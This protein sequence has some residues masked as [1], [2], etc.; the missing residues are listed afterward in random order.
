MSGTRSHSLKAPATDQPLEGLLIVA[1]G[2]CNGNKDHVLSDR[3][4]E[5]ARRSGRFCDVQV[6]YVRTEPK[7]EA[8]A[9]HMKAQRLV[10]LPLF[11][12]KGYYVKHTIPGRLA[13]GHD[14]RDMAGR[15][16]TVVQ[17]LGVSTGLAPIISDLAGQ[18]AQGAGFNVSESTLLLVAHGSTKDRASRDATVSV[19][20]RLEDTGRFGTVEMAFLEEDPFLGRQLQQVKGPIILSGLFIGEGMHGKDDMADAAAQCGRKDLVT[21]TPLS[22]SEAVTE[23]VMSELTESLETVRRGA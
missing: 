21:T 6:G 9:A 23:L 3:I 15:M 5:S 18:A 12:S 8:A 22:R 1:H 13:I 10:I 17:P 4:A 11:M 16:T 14:G 7:F 20:T 19:K 2:D